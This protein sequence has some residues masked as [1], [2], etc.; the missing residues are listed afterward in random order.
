MTTENKSRACRSF[1]RCG[2]T[3]R[4]AIQLGTLAIPGA[5][6]FSPLNAE[7]QQ[8]DPRHHR[9]RS[10][11]L[12]NLFGGPPH[13]DLFDMKPEAPTNI[14]G[15]F[16]PISS[17]VPG[18]QISELLPL[19]AQLMDRATLIRSYSHRYNSHNPYNVLTGF[20]LGVDAENYY[21]KRTDH[22]SIGAVCHWI[23][24][25]PPD[26]PSH[27]V[28][29]A[30]PGYSQALRRAGPYG[31]YL[32]TA[33]DPL[34]SSCNP[35]FARTSKGDYDAVPA[36]GVPILPAL[37]ELPD[38][39][40]GRFEKRVALLTAMNR[41]LEAAERRGAL[42]RFDD[43]SRR[44]LALLTSGR[45]RDAFDLSS[46][47]EQTRRLYG[48]GLWTSSALVARRLVEAGSRF[49]TVNW[50]AKNGNHWDLHENNFGMLRVQ[51][52]IL[53]RLIYALITDLE[54]RGLLNDTLV[55]VMGEMG[56]SPRVN[57]A[58][59]RDHWPQ[60]GFSLLF[61]GGTQRGV[62][63]GR[64]DDQGAW[65]DDR[66]VSA[67]DMVATIYHLLGVDAGLTVPDLSGRPIHISHGG[68]PVFEAIA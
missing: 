4:S 64:S 35:T 45:T 8:A 47:S 5:M 46:E 21:A 26:V 43:D 60:C 51:A 61:G 15:E 33:Y 59:G 17:S 44:A 42:S 24:P 11:I 14:R 18:I 41:Q 66:P 7:F 22:P 23:D 37:E 65:P 62:V 55:V 52:P 56:R 39:N 20:D 53:D 27:V 19:T 50:E 2:M 58:A 67:G 10:V 13:L 6:G 32:G 49:V 36:Q 28:L 9:A 68:A 12:V 63:V 16:Q 34:M 1:R 29:P 30:F 48:E 3:R 38:L 31:G 25:G 57:A 40:S 54:T